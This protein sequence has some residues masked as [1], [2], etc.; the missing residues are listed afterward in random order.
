VDTERTLTRKADSPLEADISGDREAIRRY[1]LAAELQRREEWADYHRSM[2]EL[3]RKLSEEHEEK[4]A[5]A[6]DLEAYTHRR[7]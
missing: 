6:L 1:Q 2:A 5:K 7:I 3:H 4:A